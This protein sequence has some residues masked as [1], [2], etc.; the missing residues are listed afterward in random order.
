MPTT[1]KRR[2]P[3]TK[4]KADVALTIEMMTQQYGPFTHEARLPPTD[5]MV[6]TILSQH[7][8]DINSSRAYRSL[9]ETFSSL[10]AVASA[11]VT[12]IEKA[13]ALGGLAKIK[14][15]RIKAV[16]NKILELNGTLDLSF[17]REMPLKDAKAWLR[18][19]PGIGPKSAGIVLSFSLGMPA[20]AI[21]THI[22][23]VSQRLG[24]I[25]PKVS[26]DKA[27]EILEEKVKP[28]EVFNFHVS[29]INHGRQ[30]C[31]A[32]RPLCSECVVGEFCP[33][34]KKFMSKADLATLADMEE[35][36][37]AGITGAPI[38]HVPQPETT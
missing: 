16:L 32:L 15:P 18:Q 9:M 28:E 4:S 22:Y 37:S 3:R 11:D 14:A 34:R 27:H 35:R 31:K 10:E 6:F 8:S 20:M 1:T 23:R 2:A 19:L 5:E 38:P 29:Y 13:I 36:T 24:V 21:D 30:V 17:L 25:G 12:D 33:S 7:T 26:V